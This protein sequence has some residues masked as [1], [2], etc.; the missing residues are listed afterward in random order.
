MPTFGHST[1]FMFPVCVGNGAFFGGWWTPKLIWWKV[2]LGEKGH[3]KADW[4]HDAGAIVTSQMLWALQLS[5]CERFPHQRPFQVQG[6]TGLGRI[7]IQVSLAHRR[8]NQT[9]QKLHVT[10][11]CIFIG[12]R[13]EHGR[14]EVR[15]DPA[16][17]YWITML[18]MP[19]N[20]ELW[21]GSLVF[22][23]DAHDPRDVMLTPVSYR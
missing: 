2:N 22:T 9:A 15:T 23:S 11:K 7:S 19:V 10:D 1:M 20:A 16:F 12:I 8:S 3:L 17:F 13:H 6:D 4:R 21:M 5:Y 14:D 18:R